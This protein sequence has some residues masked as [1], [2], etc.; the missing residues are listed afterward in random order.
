[1]INGTWD[2]VQTNQGSVVQQVQGFERKDTV[3]SIDSC[4]S[5]VLRSMKNP[6]YQ[7]DEYQAMEEFLVLII[8][9]HIAQ[10][11]SHNQGKTHI[12]SS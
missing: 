7:Q 2:T 11:A 6:R 8:R 5:L 3:T 10:L 12:L 4:S 9:M 1:V